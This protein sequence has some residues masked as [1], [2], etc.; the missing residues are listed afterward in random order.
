MRRVLV[1]LF[2]VLA[3]LLVAPTAAP[4]PPPTMAFPCAAFPTGQSFGKGHVREE[5][6]AGTIPAEH[7]P[8]MHR[9]YSQCARTP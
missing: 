4:Q 1:V 3:G 5:A 8:G 6:Q 2:V 9:G 7:T